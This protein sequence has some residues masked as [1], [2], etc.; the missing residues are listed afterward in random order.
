MEKN[1]RWLFYIMI[2]TSALFVIVYNIRKFFGERIDEYF[3]G[4]K[5]LDYFEV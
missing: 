1:Q 3:L 4:K 5:E 2:G